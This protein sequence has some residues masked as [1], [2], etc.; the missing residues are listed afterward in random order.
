M[1]AAPPNDSRTSL[2][3]LHRVT[4]PH[5]PTIILGSV[6]SVIRIARRW[7]CA[8]SDPQKGRAANRFG[9][10]KHGRMDPWVVD[11]DVPVQRSVAISFAF[12]SLCCFPQQC[13]H[14]HRFFLAAV[15][16]DWRIQRRVVAVAAAASRVGS[17]DRVGW[18][19]GYG[20]KARA[21]DAL[22]TVVDDSMASPGFSERSSEARRLAIGDEL[23]LGNDWVTRCG[24]AAGPR[25][26]RMG[27]RRGGK[28]RVVAVGKPEIV[29][30]HGVTRLGHIPGT[31]AERR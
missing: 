26:G 6:L 21:R 16:G 13:T 5:V 8:D 9:G 18:N 12:P 23:G 29:G 20:A 3:T 25:A 28:K 14:I 17:Q 30:R 2:T 15:N 4:M 19:Q 31:S 1:V 11:V 24:R 7:N 10:G 22:G 27:S